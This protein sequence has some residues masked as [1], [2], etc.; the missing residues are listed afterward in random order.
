MR[1][2]LLGR[3]GLRVSEFGLGTMTFGGD[4]G[5]GAD[6]DESRR[7]FEAYA[8]AGGNLVDTANNYTNGSAE[9]LVG[10]FI[11]ADRDHFVLASKYTLSERADDPNFGG[12][13]RKNLLRSVRASLQRLNTDHL[14]VLYVHAWDGTV[15]VDELMRALDDLVRAG[16]VLHLGVSDTPAWV[17][18]RAN[19]VAELRGWTPFTVLQAP[20][21]LAQRD[22]ERDLIPMAHALNLPLVAWGVLAGG[23]MTGKYNRPTTEPSRH[24]PGRVSEAR[25]SVAEAVLAVAEEVGRPAPQVAINWVR[26]QPHPVIPLMGSRSASQFRDNLGC[27]EFTLSAEHMARLSAASPIDLGFPHSFLAG[28]QVQELIH[29]ATADRL[30]R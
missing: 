17:V 14:D 3:S 21:S 28:K 7:I 26:Q 16:Q 25:K 9:R 6:A 5:W 19:T 23:I 27:L 18:A 24:D 12:N 20:Y 2:R 22:V 15:G 13:H 8:G 29:G 1:Y 11:A 10:E 30:M 4:W